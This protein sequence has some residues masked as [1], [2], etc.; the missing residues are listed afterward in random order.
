MKK[1]ICIISLMI[2]TSMCLTAQQE[3]FPRLTGSYLGQEPPGM[4]PEIFAPGII[5]VDKFSEFVCMF[6]PDQNECF[7]DRHGD[8]EYQNGAVFFSRVENDKWTEPKLYPLFTR[9]DDVFLPTLSPDGQYCFFTSK[10]LP[11]PEGVKRSIPMYFMRKTGTGWTEPKYLT[12]AIHASMT[13]EGT[14]YV[15]SGRKIEYHQLIN[16]IVDLQGM[17]PFDTG[18]PVISPDGTYLIFD[19]REM[20]GKNPCKLFVVFKN[21][22]SWTGPVSLSE[23][24]KQ[25]AFCAW[26][27]PDG[28]YILFHSLDKKKGN[29]YWI[30]ARIIEKLKPEELKK[31]SI[32]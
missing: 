27:T 19:N 28:K 23:F 20:A 9:F 22:G 21:G 26:I 14:L 18:H 12:Q 25:R 5:S 3:D 24:I 30:D 10:S 17:F 2:F 11:V 1:Q 16:S 6:T 4:K 13:L 15:N 32:K 7:F 31:A 29:I 8:D